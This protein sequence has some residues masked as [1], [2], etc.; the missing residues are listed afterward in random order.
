MNELQKMWVKAYEDY[1][2]EAKAEGRVGTSWVNGAR[3][4]ADAVIAALKR[5]E[6]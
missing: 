3:V 5:L 2:A 4:H 1:L 6:N